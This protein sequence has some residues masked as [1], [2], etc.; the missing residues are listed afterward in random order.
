ME[1]PDVRLNAS[2][3]NYV[4]PKTEEDEHNGYWDVAAHIEA[5]QMERAEVKEEEDYGAEWGYDAE[6]RTERLVK[7]TDVA[8][9]QEKGANLEVKCVCRVCLSV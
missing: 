6:R 1:V 3:R 8:P 5:R 2:R 7:H 4:D 9:E